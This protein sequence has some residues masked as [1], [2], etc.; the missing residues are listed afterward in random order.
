MLTRDEIL[1]GVAAIYKFV[2]ENKEVH[3][4]IIRKKLIHMGKVSSKEKFSKILNSM[5][6]SKNLVMDSENVSINP[7]IVGIGVLQKTREGCHIIVPHSR[8]K[9]QINRKAVEGYKNG[10]IVDIILENIE[11][12]KEAIILCKSSKTIELQKKIKEKKQEQKKIETKTTGEKSSDYILGRVIKTNHDELVFIPN[13]KSCELK[14]IPILNDKEEISAFQDKICLIKLEDPNVPFFGGKVIEVKGDAGNP[15]HEYDAIAENYGAIMKW[16]DESIQSEIE[17]IP[18]RVELDPFKLISESDAKNYQSGNIVDLRHIPFVTIDPKDCKDMDDAIY[19]TVDKNGDFVSYTAVANVTKYVKPGSEIWERYANGAFTIYAPNKAYNI[20]PTKLSTGICSLNPNEDRLA[21]VVKT[22]IDKFTGEVK[23][24]EIFDA[25][26]KSRQKYSYEQAQAIVDEMEEENPQNYLSNKIL[27]GGGYQLSPDEQ[28]LFNYYTAKT[29]KKG[30]EQRRMI[31]FNANSEREILFDDEYKN[32]LD[33]MPIE[34]LMYH[35]VIEDFMITANEATAKY[36]RDNGLPNIYRIHD[37]P[38]LKKVERANEFFNVLGIRFDGDLSAEGTRMLIDYIRNTE[39]EEIINKFLIK[40]QSRAVYSDKLHGAEQHIYEDEPVSH[41][42]LQS[43]HYSHTTSPIRRLPDFVTQHNILANMHGT[44]M[45][46]KETIE[47][48]VE[49]ANRRQLEVD[50]AEKDFENISSVLYCEKHI[51][52][53]MSGRITKIRY[54]AVG[55]NYD[56]AIVVI[57]KD[58]ARGVNVEIPLSQILGRPCLDCELSRQGCAVYDGTG[59]VVVALCK[60]VDFIID[61]ADRKTMTVTGK[62]NREL[63]KNAE[64]RVNSRRYCTKQKKTYKTTV[65]QSC[66]NIEEQEK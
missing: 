28:I 38:N 52:E 48:I 64:D 36:A 34:H 3:R 4:N 61:K 13:N 15:I 12:K 54:A 14:R 6:D 43:K 32:V 55:E 9:Y 19:S 65:S 41:Y 51:G 27:C 46:E 31:R 22:T 21:F 8:T 23:D 29:I 2:F 30:F 47:N 35:E 20:L 40:M 53:K 45:I 44:P 11:G 62:T 63:L 16:D 42:A 56:S 25:V 7:E 66:E 17:K 5:L 59:K 39:S 60:P 33:I 1:K 50:Q 18:T 10:D 58:D 24:S 49:T 26:I 37:A 57:V